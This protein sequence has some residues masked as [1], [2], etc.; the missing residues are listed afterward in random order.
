VGR[1][2]SGKKNINYYERWFRLIIYNKHNKCDVTLFA[3]ILQGSGNVY[4]F[5]RNDDVLAGGK[6]HQGIFVFVDVSSII[7]IV[8]RHKE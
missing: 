6:Y 5:S 1:Y 2:R 7:A 4:F 3:K 8:N